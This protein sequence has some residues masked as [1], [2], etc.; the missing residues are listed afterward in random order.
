MRH[1]FVEDNGDTSDA[2]IAEMNRKL[3]GEYQGEI[4]G[5]VNVDRRLKSYY[6]RNIGLSIRRG[7]AGGVLVDIMLPE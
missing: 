5:I 2:V 7:E 1:I 6:K 4:T 3:S